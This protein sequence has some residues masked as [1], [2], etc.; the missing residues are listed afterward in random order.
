MPGCPPP[1]VESPEQRRARLD[2]FERDLLPTRKV[3][4]KAPASPKRLHPLHNVEWLAAQMRY[5]GCYADTERC[6][7]R[8]TILALGYICDALENPH[9]IVNVVDH[10]PTEHSHV[11]LVRIIHEMT[12]K[13]DLKGFKC[14][15]S[16]KTIQFTTIEGEL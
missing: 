14:N 6:T 12:R 13:L 9:K 2:A 4:P 5:S 3:V 10:H 15:P 16:R 1:Y 7:G 8:T 11:E